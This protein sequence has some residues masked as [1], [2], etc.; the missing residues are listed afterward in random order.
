MKKISFV[1]WICVAVFLQSCRIPTPS[2]IVT[3]TPS[4][5]RSAEEIGSTAYAEISTLQSM[6][7][8]IMQT[9]TAI[10]ASN[11]DCQ[12]VVF[13]DGEFKNGFLP[14]VSIEDSSINYYL[15]YE[16]QSSI[17]IIYYP[18]MDKR[19]TAISLQ[20]PEY[21]WDNYL[22]CATKLTF[23]ARGEY[24]GEVVE[25]RT[26]NLWEDFD[27]SAPIGEIVLSREWEKFEVDLRGISLDHFVNGFWW[28]FLERSNPR[29]A[30]IYLDDIKFEDLQ[31]IRTAQTSISLDETAEAIDW[32]FINISLTQQLLNPTLTLQAVFDEIDSQFDNQFQGNIAF[33]RPEEMKKGDTTSIELIL[34]PSLSEA[35]LATQI[36]EQNNFIT[37]TPDLNAIGTPEPSVLI[38]PSGETVTVQTSQIEVTNYLKAELKSRDPEALIVNDMLATE[39][40][41]SF[42]EPTT[43]RW[44]VIAKKEGKHTLELIIS[45][46]IKQGDK[47]TWHEVETYKADIVVEVSPVGWVDWVKSLDWKWIVATLLIPFWLWW[48]SRNKKAEPVHVILEEKKIPKKNKKGNSK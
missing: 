44:S 23:W 10:A 15:N 37:S 32:S 25:F 26:G 47:E 29:G 14:S 8:D 11:V 9:Q 17:R 30:V 42:A 5:T 13:Q 35:V 20:A 31:H 12:V 27:Y 21:N 46:L 43:W 18:E 38:A 3:S 39:Q 7:Y 41:V 28:V 33:N 2:T 16:R 1:L 4:S 22:S 19:W 36:I 6:Q 34:S 45:Q 24:G 48:R 40:L